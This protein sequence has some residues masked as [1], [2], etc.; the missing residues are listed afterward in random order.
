[1]LK[2]VPK[3]KKVDTK[4]TAK[5]YIQNIP[6]DK[7]WKRT[8]KERLVKQALMAVR[9][10]YGEFTMVQKVEQ[11]VDKDFVQKIN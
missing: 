7:N 8:N 6:D 11:Q 10:R 5:E 9:D 1:M 4:I 2:W 3:S